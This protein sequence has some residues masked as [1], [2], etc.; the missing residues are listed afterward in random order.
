MSDASIV[1]KD[2]GKT[3]AVMGCFL[4]TVAGF[5]AKPGMDPAFSF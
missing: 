2:E 1:P 4:V 5:D 3:G